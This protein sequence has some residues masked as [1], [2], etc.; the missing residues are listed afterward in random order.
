MASIVLA[1]ALIRVPAAWLTT[2]SVYAGPGPLAF[3][4]AWRLPA[5]PIT[6]V[7]IERRRAPCPDGWYL[8]VGQRGMG[9]PLVLGLSRGEWLFEPAR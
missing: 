2:P 7:V 4:A 9:H 1:F 6:S 8:E 5:G 3:A